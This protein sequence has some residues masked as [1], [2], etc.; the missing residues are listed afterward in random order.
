MDFFQVGVT[1]GKGCVTLFPDFQISRSH[2]LMVRG[3]DF[4]AIW[5]ESE[6]TW[7]RDKLMVGETVDKELEKKRLYFEK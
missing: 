5:N 2:D 4:Y 1:Y 3:K 7:S 6:K